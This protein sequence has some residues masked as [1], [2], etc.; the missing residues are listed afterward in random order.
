M[1]LNTPLSI[2][3]VL[4]EQTTRTST[5]TCGGITKGSLGQGAT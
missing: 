4:E 2:R 1:R 5:T 3:T